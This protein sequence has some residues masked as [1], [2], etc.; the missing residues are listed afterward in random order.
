MAMWHGQ[1]TMLP[2]LN[3]R[4]YTVE[5]MVARHGDADLVARV[6]AQFGISA[7]RGAGA[8]HRKRN[9]GGAYALRT[10]VKAL[11]SGSIVAMTADVPQRNPRIAGESIVTLAQ[12]SGRPIIPRCRRDVPILRAQHMEPADGQSPVFETGVGRGQSDLGQAGRGRCRY[13]AGQTSSSR[14]SQCHHDASLR[15]CESKRTPA[16]PAR[17]ERNSEP[18]PLVKR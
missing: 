9:R 16:T 12:L 11:E 6:L 8:G 3:T 5:A 1:F 7:I 13:R 17:A 14:V 15:A 2:D 4:E 10:A 18:I